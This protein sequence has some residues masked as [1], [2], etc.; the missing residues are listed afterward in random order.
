MPRSWCTSAL[1]MIVSAFIAAPLCAQTT[2]HLHDE[3][4]STAGLSQLKTAGPDVARVVTR[5]ANLKKQPAGAATIRTFDTQGGVP[6]R[7]GVIPG[8]STVT[9]TIW[10]KK[11]TAAG[12]VFPKASLGL[13]VPVTTSLCEGTGTTALTTT[14]TAFTFSCTTASPIVMQTTDRLTVAAGYSM[15]VGPGNKNMKVRLDVEGKL[16]KSADSR[17]VA[18]NPVPPGIASVDP[19]S[20]EIN[21]SVTVTGANFGPPRESST[22][23]FNGSATAPT[24]WTNTHITAPVPA[25]ATSGP[26]VVTVGGAASNG[27]AFTVIRAPSIASLTPSTGLVGHSVSIAGSN[28]GAPQG[29]STLTFNGTAATPTAWSETSIAATVP[30]GATSGPVVVR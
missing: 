12:T 19:T 28:F 3:P 10:M 8:G 26:V 2:Y 27:F 29:S 21:A 22:L 14:L 5:T 4:S 17:V 30:P 18:P 25:G 1:A 20:A 13:N 7:G 24:S 16:N 6:N 23:T 11:S 9:F 15:T